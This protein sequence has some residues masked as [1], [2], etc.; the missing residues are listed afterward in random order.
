[1]LPMK[2]LLL[3][4]AVAAAALYLA[5]CGNS[6][7]AG[8]GATPAGP[9]IAGTDK[10]TGNLE[11][12]A[13]KGGYGIDFYEGAAKE[14]D[15][16]N[17]GVTTKV[18]G[19]PRVWEKLR[20]SFVAGTPPDL[21]FPGWGMD[22][23]KLAG[24]GELMVLNKALDSPPYGAT[25]GTWRDTFEPAL[26]ALGALDG[27]QYVLPYY[28][29][30]DG[31]WYDPG[32]FAKHGWKPPKTYEELLTLCPLI[33]AAGM[34]PLTFQG[35]YPYYM[36]DGMLLPWAFSVGGAQ[37]VKDAQNLV[38]GAWKSPAML[39]AAHM[40]NDLKLK[41]YFQEGAVA[42]THTESQS[43]FLQGHA[44]MIPCGTWL[45]S[46]MSKVM[47]PGAKM[48]FMLPP[49]SANGKGDPTNVLIGIEP[50]MVPS[51]AKNPNAA[52]Q[53]FKY[54]TSLDKAKEFVQ[55]KGT[56]MA[57]KDS[58]QTKLPD[59]LITPSKVFKE[60]KAVWSD[61]LRYWYP[62]LEKE[63][64]DAL[65]AMLTGDVTPEQF[66]DRVEAQAEKTR[67]DKGVLKHKVAG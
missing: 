66:C 32:V 48:E 56:L 4:S 36:I 11:V 46:E 34:A 39:Q 55:Q 65:T 7:G 51:K 61:E 1:M 13:F 6:G 59:V 23:W 54:M 24:D 18:W 50:W 62:E 3:L 21:V 9:E 22:H 47:P 64:E 16:K 10:P 49:V 43:E 52:V 17:P 58:D 57:I 5:G 15:Q 33:K 53:L 35:K 31:W 67:N 63:M 38:P 42:M 29:N 20:T 27:K 26:L 25:T 41:G 12:A 14:F 2:K 19:D 40:I 45:Y 37:A 8:G 30:V 28:F 60:S 44:A